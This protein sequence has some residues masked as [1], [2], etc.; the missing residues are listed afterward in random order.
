MVEAL[1]LP[2]RQAGI[3]SIGSRQVRVDPLHLEAV[4]VLECLNQGH[5]LLPRDPQAGHA[6]VQIHVDRQTGA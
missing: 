2:L 1:L 4:Q 5:P 6:G 3:N